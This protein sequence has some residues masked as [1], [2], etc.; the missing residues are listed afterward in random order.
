MSLPKKFIHFGCWGEPKRH[1]EEGSNLFNAIRKRSVDFYTVAGDNYYPKKPEKDKTTETKDKKDKKDRKT[2]KL[3][4]KNIQVGEIGH[5]F[6][7]LF[8]LD[9]LNKKIYMMFGNHE[10]LDIDLNTKKCQSLDMEINLINLSNN[11]QYFKNILVQP[12]E[13]SVVIMIDTTIY[14]SDEYKLNQGL[15]CYSN[16]KILT[17]HDETTITELQESQLMQIYGSLV[18]MLDKPNI[19]FIGHHPIFSL[20][21]KGGQLDDEVNKNLRDMFITVDTMLNNALTNKTIYYLCA[22]THFYEEAT[23]TFSGLTIK[24]YI[25]GTGGAKPDDL[26]KLQKH[27]KDDVDYVKCIPEEKKHID[28][29]SCSWTSAGNNKEEEEGFLEIVDGIN[30]DIRFFRTG[31]LDPFTTNRP[32]KTKS[33]G[34]KGKTRRTNKPK[35]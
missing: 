12:M 30:I 17:N 22:D 1:P 34:A 26:S 35:K 21:E 19:I 9:K 28:I 11:I 3:K 13:H 20:K 23:L 16:H 2:K 24:Q 32:V 27:F 31:S 33:N 25:V 18:S 10:I 29:N 5:L 7:H 6:R 15:E 4:P 8:E 14:E